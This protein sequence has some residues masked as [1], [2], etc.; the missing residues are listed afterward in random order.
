MTKIEDAAKLVEQKSP[1]DVVILCYQ[2]PAD[3]E[4]NSIKALLPLCAGREQWGREAEVSQLCRDCTAP[5][6]GTGL[7]VPPCHCSSRQPRHKLSQQQ[8]TNRK[9]AAMSSEDLPS[10]GVPQI[11]K[12][13]PAQNV[14]ANAWL[15][16]TCSDSTDTSLNS[17]CRVL[18]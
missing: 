2:M 3:T 13:A 4:C 5:G 9:Q 18:L 1:K 10:H 14:P 12:T 15:L 7:P 17:W 16:I 6:Q 8:V 11:T